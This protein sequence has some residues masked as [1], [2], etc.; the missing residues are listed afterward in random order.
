V[1]TNLE[2]VWPTAYADEQ[3][4]VE[5]EERIRPVQKLALPHCGYAIAD[6][7]FCVASNLI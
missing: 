6:L 5:S 1:N 4:P 2:L 3:R 7:V